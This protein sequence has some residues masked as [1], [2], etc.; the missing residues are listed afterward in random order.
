MQEESERDSVR[1][2]KEGLK[3]QNLHIKKAETTKI[4]QEVK[5]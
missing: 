2:S 3:P 1:R 4:K 5:K